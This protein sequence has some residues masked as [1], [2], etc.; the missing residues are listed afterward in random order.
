MMERDIFHEPYRKEL[1]PD[2][3]LVRE[4]CHQLGAYGMTISGAGPSIFIAGEKG[5]QQ[6]VV[7]ALEKKFAFYREPETDN[8]RIGTY[9]Q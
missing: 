3:D 2:F 5:T 4:A 9:V 1:L 8:G 7:V 6:S